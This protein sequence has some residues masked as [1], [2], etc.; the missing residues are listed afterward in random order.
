METDRPALVRA[1]GLN[2]LSLRPGGFQDSGKG[3]LNPS[4]HRA[5]LLHEIHMYDLSG[6][7][8]I[9]TPRAVDAAPSQNVPKTW[10]R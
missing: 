2:Y 3:Y 6:V 7:D 8:P 5:G 9:L 10:T 1:L 4:Q